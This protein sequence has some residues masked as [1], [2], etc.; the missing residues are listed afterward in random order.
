MIPTVGRWAEDRSMTGWAAAAALA[1][2]LALTVS[3]GAA[4][5]TFEAEDHSYRVVTVAEGLVNPWG[6]AFL[7]GGDMLVTERPGRLRIIRN[8]Q[9][10]ATPIAGVPAV[11][12]MGQ[13]G[14]LDVA[15]HPDFAQNRL[16]YLSYS[17]ANADGSEGTTAIVRGRLEGDALVDVQEIFEA[18][19]WSRTNGHFGS[20]MVLDDGY[21]YFTV[22]DRQAPPVNDASHPAQ[23]L[24]NHQGTVIRL[25][26]DGRVPEDNPFVGQAGALPEIWAYG[27]RS[28][29]G[30]VQHPTTGMLWE[31]E[32]GP[33]GGDE[34][35]VIERGRNYGWPIITYGINYNGQPITD[36]TA[37]EGLEQPA[38]YWVPSI[39]TSGLA[40]YTGSA[41][42]DWTG[43]LLAGGLTGQYLARLTV[44]GTR[45]VAEEKL[46][47]GYGERIRD[48]RDGP[49]GFIYVLTDST[50]GRVIRL[51]P[52]R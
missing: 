28:P 13:G 33:R 37:R 40:F 9:L 42:P 44:D 50:E 16:V 39:A 8:G 52:V 5:Q 41:F 12:A 31:L 29:Q 38:H 21:I 19:A 18:R 10:Q 26:D 17:K 2:T 27:I 22:G 36:I 34:V 47:D 3:P 7:P 45:I 30:L 25:H 49:D 14:L 15:L 48:V 43:S 6:L 46:L 51:E 20:R 35:N 23:Q 24:G 4:Q 32:H 11:R 1:A